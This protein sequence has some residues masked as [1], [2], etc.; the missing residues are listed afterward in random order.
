MSLGNVGCAT[1]TLH[2]H[3]R[4]R[5]SHRTALQSGGQ[6]PLVYS[7]DTHSVGEKVAYPANPNGSV[8]GIAG[9]CNARGNVFGLMPHPER[10]VH[11]LQHPQRH[12][13]ADG[14]GDGI[15]IFKNA[16]DYASELS[17]TVSPHKTRSKGSTRKSST[18]VGSAYANSGVDIAAAERAKRLMQDAV[19]STHGAEVLAGMGAFA[20][21][22]SAQSIQK[23]QHPAFVS[24]TDG[25][26]TK[27]LLASQVRRFDTIGFDLV[28]HS[29]NDLLT[30]GAR[31]LFFMD[32]LAMGRLDAVQA[33]KIVRSV[34][35]ACQEVGCALLGGETAEMPDVYQ[36]GAFDL[37]GT[38]VGVV[39]QEE[40]IDGK[41]IC[42]GDV[43]VGLPSSGLHTNGYSLARQLFAPYDLD[44]VFP[45]LG[46]PLVEAL[47][48]PHRSYLRE[49]NALREYL[50]DRKRY[51]K[52]IAHI[53]GGGFE[54]NISR[55][56]PKG[57]QAVI[58]T[59]SWQVPPLFKLL[60][61]LGNIEHDELYRAFNMGIGMVL[62]LS[63][64]G[65]LDARCILPKL[66]TIGYIKEGKGV[67]LH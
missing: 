64:K 49:I 66:L 51:I 56:L 60:A 23:M 48:R 9:V 34:A 58:E 26:G 13:T 6:V 43:L 30:Q 53:T 32:Y 18:K 46:E 27:T 39:E 14:Q 65:A 33:A 47:L 40:V 19:R 22:Y 4:H 20:G 7:S 62:V 44:T 63:P 61:K 38:I 16:Y 67:R 10:Y 29:V 52:G 37:A 2:L 59:D 21:I 8:G 50:A 57:M 3:T 24:S 12:A 5:S 17:D 35:D 41:T 36:P 28:N 25:V 11:S 15:L 42:A 45:E 1:G 31:P 55:I 54:G